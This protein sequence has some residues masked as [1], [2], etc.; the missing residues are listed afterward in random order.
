MT[1]IKKPTTPKGRGVSGITGFL[2]QG[3]WNV[4]EN[5]EIDY[6]F[7]MSFRYFIIELDFDIILTLIYYHLF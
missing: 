3:R 2:T 5:F 7:L 4:Y 6:N 1:T